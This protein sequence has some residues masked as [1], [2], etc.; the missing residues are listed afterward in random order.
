[1]N[2]RHISIASIAAVSVL[3]MLSGAA[4]ADNARSDV[5]GGQ[6]VVDGSRK[7]VGAL[8]AP[9]YAQSNFDGVWVGY[10]VGP[11]GFMVSNDFGV[12]YA[13][14][15]CAGP[16][17]MDASTLPVKGA[18]IK[19]GAQTFSNT[20]ALYYPGLPVRQIVATSMTD[21][22]NNCQPLDPPVSMVVGPL[23]K[24][25]LAGYALPFGVK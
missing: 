8:L 17:F 21:A 4:R 2:L 15:N 12:F 10:N 5:G 24:T 6:T 25:N 9:G 20:G 18:V 16:G 11:A 19:P 13:S 7:H 23:T 3:A 14:N 1:M 22:S